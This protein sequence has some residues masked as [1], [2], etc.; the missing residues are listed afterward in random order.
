MD[1]QTLELLRVLQSG[2]HDSRSFEG[3]AALLATQRPRLAAADDRATLADVS[4]L[5][6]VWAES[7]P[8]AMAAA[9]LIHAAQIAEDDLQQAERAV[10]LYT[11]SLERDPGDL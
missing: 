9:A 8:P 11:L 10:Q 4:E 6:E 5:L 3:I 1:P 7:A 2:G